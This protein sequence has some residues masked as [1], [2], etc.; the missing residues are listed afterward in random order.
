MKKTSLLALATMVLAVTNIALAVSI[1]QLYYPM[2]AEVPQAAEIK[3][4][5]DSSLNS[6]Y[7]LPDGT[8]IDWGTVTSGVNTKY[9]WIENTGNCPVSLN[10]TVQNLPADWSLTW[11]SENYNLNVGQS[12]KSTLT[13]TVPTNATSGIY[14]WSSWI[15][16]TAI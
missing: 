4:Y 3:V 13:L 10:L 8:T 15:K 1:Y 2:T 16:A 14:S 9:L 7:L 11:D 5:S 12:I 6:T